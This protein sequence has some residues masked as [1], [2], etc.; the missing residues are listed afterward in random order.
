MIDALFVKFSAG[1][2]VQ[3]AT[4]KRAQS[5]DMPE[6]FRVLVHLDILPTEKGLTSKMTKT[7]ATEIFKKANKG[8]GSDEDFREMDRSEFYKAMRLVAAKLGFPVET[9]DDL[10]G[11]L[12]GFHQTSVA[13]NLITDT[14]TPR[15]LETETALYGKA[16]DDAMNQYIQVCG[17]GW[18]RE[19][20]CVH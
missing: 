17:L 8:A 12:T 3:R 9:D 13:E 10:N 1:D 16:Y 19:G 15:G 20:V 11:L 2:H 18:G 4:A 14:A 6:F 5:M 7:E